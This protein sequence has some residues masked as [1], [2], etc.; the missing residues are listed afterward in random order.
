M[1]SRN[2]RAGL[3]AG[4]RERVELLI[5]DSSL[6]HAFFEG[7]PA[8]RLLGRVRLASDERDARLAAAAT[9]GSR[10]EEVGEPPST[11]D[12][13]MRRLLAGEELAM[14]RVR[15]AVA[16]H[17]RVASDEGMLVAS[18]ATVAALTLAVIWSVD[19]DFSL[20]EIARAP[21]RCDS[22]P[23]AHACA[24]YD[25]RLMTP[26][27]DP[28][29]PFFE[30]C[31][32]LAARARIG[33]WPWQRLQETALLLSGPRL[34]AMPF[35]QIEGTLFPYGAVD[36]GHGSLTGPQ[37]MV[38]ID[39]TVLDA[40]VSMDPRVLASSIARLERDGEERST[41]SLV[42]D[43]TELLSHAGPLVMAI[44]QRDPP[45]A[46]LGERVYPWSP[47]RWDAPD[48]ALTLADAL[49]NGTVT[50]PRAGALV[51]KGGEPALDAIGA[52]MLH[53]ASHPFASAAFA[54]LVARSGRPRDVIRLVTYFATAPDLEVAARA[55]ASCKAPELPRVL[56]AWLEAM[57]P[58]DG[59]PAPAGDDPETSSAARLMA[60]V[61]ALTPYPLLYDAARPLLTRIDEASR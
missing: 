55:L 13:L 30:A 56:A 10:P 35:R 33:P 42:A 21:D 27:V 32:R 37:R 51:A 40:V 50:L 11:W 25:A 38:E 45:P 57:L 6:A 3:E 12:V 43:L 2:V 48:A 19:I 17:A 29:I 4:A 60:C 24:K 26:G 20:A 7:I 44:P 28:R 61:A 31:V 36:G 58:T 23:V 8:A 41:D 59:E 18:D 53:V 49:E 14:E 39:R 54:E 15:R 47:N 34:A 22:C 46:D 9:D 5:S 1:E 52:E 16:R